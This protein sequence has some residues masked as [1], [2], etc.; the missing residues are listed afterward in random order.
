MKKYLFSLIALTMAFIV[1]AAGEPKISFNATTH[2][3]GTIKEADGEVA[4]DFVIKNTGT[5]PLIIVSA[6]ASCGCTT[7][8]I[9]REP[10]K[11]GGTAKLKVIYDPT[12]RP[13]EFEKTVKIKSNIKGDRKALRIKGVVVPK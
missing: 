2:D 11:P 9:P 7:P 10:I 6:S 4:Y 12:G 3:F 1:M 8:K 13:G 5:A